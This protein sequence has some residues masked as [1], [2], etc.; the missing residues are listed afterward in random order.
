MAVEIKILAALQAAMDE[1][2]KAA[3]RAPRGRDSFSYGEVVGHYAGLTQALAI[4]E[5]AM[6]PE[7]EEME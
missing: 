6:T 4:V 5:K 3:M 1:H 2:S 7:T